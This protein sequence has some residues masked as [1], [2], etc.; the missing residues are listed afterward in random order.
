MG[1][2]TYRVAG[3]GGPAVGA[4]FRP[5]ADGGAASVAGTGQVNLWVNVTT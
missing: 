2:S 3:A 4:G 1:A 5:V